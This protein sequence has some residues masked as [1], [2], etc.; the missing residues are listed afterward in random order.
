MTLEDQVP[1]I[2]L[3]DYLYLDVDRVKS[4]AGQLDQGVEEGRSFSRRASK[5]AVIGWEKFLSFTPESGTESTI[6]RSMLDSLFPDLESS[7]EA[8]LMRDISDEFGDTEVPAYETVREK[9]PEGSLVRLTAPGYL[10]DS[11]YLGS[12]LVNLS[13]AI[14]G[15]QWVCYELLKAALKEAG[16]E[17]ANELADLDFLQ[18]SLLKGEEEEYERSL[19]EFIPEFGYTANFLRAIVRTTRGILP[20]GLNLVSFSAQGKVQMTANTR[21]QRERRYLEA[22]PDIIGSRFGATPQDWTVVGTVGH[23]SQLPAE[24]GLTHK[25]A[26]ETLHDFQEGAKQATEFS[27]ANFLKE[28]TKMLS[29][30]GRL[31]FLNVP[32]HPGMTI[33]PMAIYRYIQ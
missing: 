13:T 8:T 18:S 30:L 31:G 10:F 15:Y 17:S 24:I 1:K 33:I 16:E 11:T 23:Y 20:P 9:C 32:Q 4:I 12:S 29:E 7:L 27:R 2:T 19:H 6:Q 26:I 14:N 22:D 3:R 5:K 21:L 25:S 28:V